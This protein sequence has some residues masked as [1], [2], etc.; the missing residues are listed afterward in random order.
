MFTSLQKLAH[1]FFLSLS[2]IFK[3]RL[4]HQ[5]VGPQPTKKNHSSTLHASELDEGAEYCYELSVLVSKPQAP[6]VA[7][8]EAS[9][10]ESTC[11]VHVSL[12]FISLNLISFTLLTLFFF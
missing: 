4:K 11:D 9:Q 3:V 5:D 8:R 10:K 7:L 6:A 2:L 12:M 1:Y